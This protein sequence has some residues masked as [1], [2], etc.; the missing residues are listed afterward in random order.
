MKARLV[1]LLILAAAAPVWG[2]DLPGFPFI[3][4]T[5]RAT[6]EVSPDLAKVNF[7]VKTRDASAEVAARTASERVQQVLDLLTANGIAVADIDAHAISKEV[8]FERDSGISSGVRRGSPRYEVSRSFSVVVRKVPSWPD[9]GSKLLEMQ[10]VEDLAAQFDRTDR[11][12]LEAE[13]LTAAAHDAQRRAEL[14]A[15]GFGQHLGAVQAISQ[16]PF[17]GISGRF[18]GGAGNFYAG[19]DREFKV[20][21]IAERGAG[22]QLLVPVT[23]S[24]GASVNAI[25][26]L[27]GA[28]R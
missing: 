14:I 23:I 2:T 8:V 24:L 6:R 26:R 11:P 7:T 12:A 3:D 27:E 22:A 18:L 13:L 10:N 9:V 28:Q 1:C 16:D 4:V 25:Y 20:S 19:A 17:E 21:A 15:A 5:G